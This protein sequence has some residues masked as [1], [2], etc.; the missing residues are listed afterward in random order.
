MGRRGWKGTSC[1]SDTS[2][3]DPEPGVTK[4]RNREKVGSESR[5]WLPSRGWELCGLCALNCLM[6]A[7]HLPSSSQSGRPCWLA[8]STG[9]IAETEN[10]DRKVSQCQAGGQEPKPVLMCNR[11]HAGSAHWGQAWGLEGPAPECRLTLSYEGK[12]AVPI[13][14]RRNGST[15]GH[16]HLPMH[17]SKRQSPD[18]NKVACSRVCNADVPEKLKENRKAKLFQRK[19][20]KCELDLVSYLEITDKAKWRDLILDNILSGNSRTTKQGKLLQQSTGSYSTILR[21]SPLRGC[22]LA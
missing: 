19:G 21:Y 7:N 6:G 3:E 22:S 15:E 9:W 8:G 13:F 12:V 4:K 5:A 20:K 2:E 18:S 1:L 17:R 16:S 11:E 14:Q 10:G